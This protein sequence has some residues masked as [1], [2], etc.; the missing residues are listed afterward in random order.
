MTET[1]HRPV[2]MR[3]GGLRGLREAA[4]LAE[5]Q[6]AET[7]RTQYWLADFQGETLGLRRFV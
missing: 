6:R 4:R 1:R 3:Q 2:E 5:W 7:A